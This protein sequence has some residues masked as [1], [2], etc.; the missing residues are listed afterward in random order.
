MKK[1]LLISAL[2]M[3]VS[4]SAMAQ[5]QF[6]AMPSVSIGVTKLGDNVWKHGDKS[7]FHFSADAILGVAINNENR[8]FA[9]M[10]LAH[11]SYIFN[12][13][14]CDVIDT[15]TIT[16]TTIGAQGL[17]RLAN[18]LTF[19]AAVG[20]KMWANIETVDDELF[21]MDK[22]NRE[23]VAKLK[24]GYSWDHVALLA[25]IGADGGFDTGLSVSF[26]LY[27]TK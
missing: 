21:D 23:L 20:V 27:K 9:G 25:Y 10:L 14:A 11:D 15:Y 18:R 12:Q 2:T 22:I 26:P 19:G 1:L 4:A 5:M 24:V 17:Y 3:L 16:S 13:Q 6:L 8:I 7:A